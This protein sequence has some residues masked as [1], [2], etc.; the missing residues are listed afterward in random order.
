MVAL[1]VRS[2]GMVIV[3]GEAP[4]RRRLAELSARASIESQTTPPMRPVQI[5][6]LFEKSVHRSPGRWPAIAI[7]CKATGRMWRSI[8][9][10]GDEFGVPAA[11]IDYAIKHGRPFR[12]MILSI[13][14][15]EKAAVA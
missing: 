9:Q 11:N 10:C 14:P 1:P 13:I 2:V 7:E 6:P 4:D 15:R 5:L 12:G 8:S 3:R